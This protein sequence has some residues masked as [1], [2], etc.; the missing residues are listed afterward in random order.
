[1]RII[2]EVGTNVI[3]FLAQ[4][5]GFQ[6]MLWEKRKFA[7]D[8]QYCVAARLIPGR[9]L[10]QV[11]ECEA[12]WE[13]WRG[14]GCVA[15]DN[16]LFGGD[17]GPDARREFLERNPGLLLDTRHFEPQFVDYL[18]ATLGDIDEKTDGLAIRSENWQALNLLGER[19]REALSC[20]Y[21][22]PPYNTAASAILYNTP[23]F[24]KGQREAVWQHQVSQHYGSETAIALR[25]GATDLMTYYAR[26]KRVAVLSNW[27]DGVPISEIE[28]SFTVNPFNRIRAGDIRGFAELARLHLAAAREIA[29]VLLVDKGP[30]GKEIDTLLAQLEA[31]IPAGALDAPVPP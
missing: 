14:L 10:S 31:G 19:Y 12:Q 22:D 24:R 26:C 20:V 25:W 15:V 1:M 4:I 16:S 23:I 5:E 11:V 13:A 17:D 9:L 2:R 29:D 6:K 21:I 28:S 3:E 30:S 18:L 7:V 8:V 27:T